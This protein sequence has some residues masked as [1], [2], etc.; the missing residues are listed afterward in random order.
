[1]E[2]RACGIFF[3][4]TILVLYF[5]RPKSAVFQMSESVELNISSTL[6][7]LKAYHE[8]MLNCLRADLSGRIA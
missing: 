1:M 8:D 6:R 4:L 3:K 7:F 5:L 2:F